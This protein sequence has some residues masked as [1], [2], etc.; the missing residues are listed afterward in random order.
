MLTPAL[1]DENVKQVHL[2]VESTITRLIKCLSERSKN[3][4]HNYV[5]II[6]INQKQFRVKE[7]Y[8]DFPLFIHD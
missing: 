8:I 7:I 1:S 3:N 2:Y 6:K 4:I 5:L